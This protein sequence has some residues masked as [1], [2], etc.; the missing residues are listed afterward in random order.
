MSS[1]Q[2]LAA[3]EQ[4]LGTLRSQAEQELNT[5]TNRIIALER[6]VS[7]HEERQ[8]ATATYMEKV[9]RVTGIRFDTPG[10]AQGTQAYFR[11]TKDI[12]ESKAIQG[13]GVFHGGY[14]G[15]YKEW[16]AK[17]VNVFTQV[18]GGTREVPAERAWGA[19][20]QAW[21]GN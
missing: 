4:A 17:F 8:T 13:L 11:Q 10:T 20:M 5:A 3:L 12:S 19:E 15:Y 21:G 9:Q 14:K 16:H 2:R 7:Q 1:E 18:R 6:T